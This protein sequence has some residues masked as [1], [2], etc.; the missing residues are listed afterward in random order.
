VAEKF[1]DEI[2]DYAKSKGVSVNVI[3]MQGTDCRLSL[4]GRVADKTNGT[5][6]IVNPLNLG[7]QFKSILENRVIA[8][9]V[10]AKLI[11]SKYLYIRDEEFETAE[12]K[13]IDSGN[14]KAKEELN[15][16][17]KSVVTKDIGNA[18]VDT[19]ITFEYGIR[20]LSEEERKNA[21]TLKEV[22][23]Q[24]QISYTAPDGTKALRVFT[25][26]QE[27]TRDRK[28]AEGNI[29]S[30]S[31]LFMNAAQRMANHALGSN[32]KFAKYRQNQMDHLAMANNL[33]RPQ[34]YQQQ[35]QQVQ[36]FSNSR[37]ARDF[38]DEEANQMFRAKK[39]NRKA[40]I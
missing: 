34:L 36:M 24:L 1:Y 3:T 21:P 13:A 33:N 40:M 30:E 35:A 9:N 37:N 28:L 29:E 10:T 14:A 6:N 27:F 20:T 18:N 39:V 11:V 7:Q 22:P 15:K 25:K 2:A 12:L 23:F 31:L 17:K 4:L 19:E 8:T 5:L 26:L 16:I 32:V 38:K